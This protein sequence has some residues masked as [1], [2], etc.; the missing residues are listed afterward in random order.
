MLSRNGHLLLLR[1][2]ETLVYYCRSVLFIGQAPFEVRTPYDHCGEFGLLLAELPLDLLE[3]GLQ[4]HAQ[5]GERIGAP[6]GFDLLADY[7]GLCRC[8]LCRFLK[9]G[10]PRNVGACLLAVA[11]SLAVEFDEL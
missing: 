9:L 7:L 10:G 3:W 5:C 8:C 1:L 11:Q 6:G 4:A 2:R